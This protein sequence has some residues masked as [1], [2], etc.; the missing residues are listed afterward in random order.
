MDERDLLMIPGPTN[1]DPVVLR[2]MSR[3]TLSH[4]SDA[5]ATIFKET[6]EDLQRIFVTTGPVL[7]LAGSGTLGAE[8]ALGNIIERGDRVLA[9]SGGYFGDRLA[10]VATT[11]GAAVDKIELPWGSIANPKEVNTRLKSGDYKTLL[12]VHVDTS[13][14]AANP[15]KE[16][17]NVT[18]ANDV[19]FVLDAVCS[20]GGMPL[21]V[22]DWNIDV[23]FT[24]SQKALAVPPGLAIISFGPRALAAR[25]QRKSP[26]GTYYGDINR[27]Q[28]VIQ[29]PTKYF[30][31]PAVNMMYALHESCR[32][33]LKEGLESRI[34]R[35]T[36]LAQAF[37]HAMHSLGLRLLCDGEEAA[38]TLSVVYSPE[39]VDES[40]LRQTMAEKYGVTVAGGLG[41]TKGKAFRVG[42]MGNITMKDILATIAAIE[43]ALHE[44]G[45]DFAAGAGVASALNFE[46]TTHKTVTA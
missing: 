45:F 25:N 26:V 9:V 44:Q 13:T 14:G 20:L 19:L 2:S 29:D 18:R 30:A 41:P 34:D 33:I 21:R 40:R 39:T 11:L 35:H 15:A 23:C 22:D 24:G 5:F 1:V 4:V 17:G 38:S 6:V 43:G 37:R 46:S 8:V 31:T 12:A 28:P 42:H 36:K 10:E 7:P 27:W 32:M 3:A 16:L